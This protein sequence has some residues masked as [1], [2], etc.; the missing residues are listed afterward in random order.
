MVPKR[1]AASGRARQAGRGGGDQ[2]VSRIPLD[3]PTAAMVHVGVGVRLRRVEII[4][5]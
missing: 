5:G 2:R 3:R 1:L 4:S